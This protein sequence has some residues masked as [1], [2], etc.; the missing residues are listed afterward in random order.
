MAYCTNQQIQQII[1]ARLLGDLVVDTGIRQT[2]SQLNSDANLTLA[3]STASGLIN[4][5]ALVSERYTV[6]E[7]QGLTGD[8]ANFLVMMCAWLAFGILCSRR[9]RDPKERPE[10]EQVLQMIEDLK[11]GAKMFNVAADVAV[12]TP[13]EDFP[14][15]QNYQTV[16]TL[17]TATNF[18]Y[19]IRR[20]QNVAQ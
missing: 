5:A 6:A 13:N 18:Y 16:N 1:D 4:S 3:L 10:Y 19:P 15:A 8:D 17:R 9:G 2:P 7:L 12:G 11:Q 14:S 20:N